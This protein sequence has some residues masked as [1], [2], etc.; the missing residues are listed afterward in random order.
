VT[1]LLLK[2]RARPRGD[3]I[4]MKRGVTLGLVGYFVIGLV[5]LFAEYALWQRQRLAPEQPIA[6]SHHRH[7]AQNGL[8]CDKCHAYADKGP[9]ATVPAMSICAEC[10]AQMKS[11]DAEIVRLQGYFRDERPVEWARIHTLPWHARFSHKYH[12]R[13]G[14]ACETCHGEVRTMIRVRRMRSLSMGWC[15]ACHRQKGASDDCVVC[16]R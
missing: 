11:N 9:R 1:R 3:V 12:L 5:T 6:F 15:V 7:V 2:R 14:V 16:H 4:M 10:H 8:V 13:R